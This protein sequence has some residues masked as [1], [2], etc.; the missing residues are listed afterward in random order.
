MAKTS[1]ESMFWDAGNG[2]GSESRLSL[3]EFHENVQNYLMRIAEP[4][5][6]L[7][8][9]SMLFNS[10][11]Y[12]ILPI[13]C[14]KTMQSLEEMNQPVQE[15]SRL[16][17]ESSRLPFI[18]TALSYRLLSIV[19]LIEDQTNR[20]LD[21]IN[22]YRVICIS[23]SQH[24]KHLR[25]EIDKSFERLLENTVALSTRVELLNNEAVEEERKLLSFR[26]EQ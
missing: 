5:F 12:T 17:H 22:S 16:L 11:D 18:F 9:A 21:L 10:E 26:K 13:Q 25:K 4:Q 20:L 1:T 19:N 7:K 8:L 23:P 2:R 3:E 6:S 24:E 14:R 15:L